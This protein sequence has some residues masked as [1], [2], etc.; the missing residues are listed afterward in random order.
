MTIALTPFELADR[1][2]RYPAHGRV[3]VALA[4]TPGSG[5]STLAEWLCARLNAD[6]PDGAAVLPM[7]GY[8]FDDRVLEA[9]GLRARKGAPET[10]DVAGL[11]HMLGRLKL[12][13][14]DEIAV[15]VFDR[16]LEIARAG[17]R[18]IPR[19]V[20]YLIV[21]GNYLLIGRAPWSALRGLFDVTVMIEVPEET[22]RERLRRRWQDHGLSPHE[23]TAKVE[24]NDMPNG[25]FV[26][27]A[28]AAADF[29]VS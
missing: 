13:E 18:L 25:R 9:R 12:N 23:V 1:I 3:I 20:R 11:R 29:I 26:R 19:G 2:R 6:V 22:L 17:A 24:G 28:S 8:H 7:D 21:E 15:P 27:D 5:K 10:F 16:D 4:G 14:E